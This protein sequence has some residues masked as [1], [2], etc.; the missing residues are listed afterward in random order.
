MTSNSISN[1]ITT[2]FHSFTKYTSYKYRA[3]IVVNMDATSEQELLQS[4][5]PSLLRKFPEHYPAKAK[6]RRVRRERNDLW[7]SEWG[8]LLNNPQTMIPGTFEYK[9]FRL[10]FRVPYPVFKNRLIPA[11]KEA[12]IFNSERR[13]YIPLAFKVMVSLRIIGRGTDCDTAGELSGIPKST[14]NS[15]FKQFC[16]GFASS[17]Y[18]DFVYFP[19]GDKAE[20]QGKISLSYSRLSSDC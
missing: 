1:E 20:L 9:K 14:C 17:F 4:V 13:S 7:A 2:M 3:F 5:L 19:S 10:R 16:E 11:I 8:Q 15:L 18:D 12:K 6:K